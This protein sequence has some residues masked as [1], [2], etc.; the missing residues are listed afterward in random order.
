METSFHSTDS[1]TQSAGCLPDNS[2]QEVRSSKEATVP[3]SS[4]S[5]QELKFLS[6]LCRL[7]CL[8]YSPEI[9]TFSSVATLEKI[10]VEGK[11]ILFHTPASIELYAAGSHIRVSELMKKALFP[12]SLKTAE[13]SQILD[14]ND[15]LLAFEKSSKYQVWDWLS[16]VNPRRKCL[17]KIKKNSGKR[18]CLQPGLVVV[19]RDKREKYGLIFDTTSPIHEAFSPGEMA[20]SCTHILTDYH[21]WLSVKSEVES[22]IKKRKLYLSPN[23][24]GVAILLPSIY[25]GLTDELLQIGRE[26]NITTPIYL[27]DKK[28]FLEKPFSCWHSN[29]I[30]SKLLAIRKKLCMET[31]KSN[32]VC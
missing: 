2:R 26:L 30:G 20:C 22:W 6:T 24:V 11:P 3:P 9:E 21:A 13:I 29:F 32:E 18:G 7:G 28:S 19:L 16:D 5:A 31:K 15:I 14:Q 23:N 10:E 25:N 8:R 17:L 4:V 1:G 27:A 12:A